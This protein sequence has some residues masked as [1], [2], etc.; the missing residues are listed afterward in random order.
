MKK[1]F[2]LIFLATL[3][4]S[5]CSTTG[6]AET[7]SGDTYISSNLPVDYEGALPVRNQLALGT[8][9]LIEANQ[10]PTAEQAKELIVLWQALRSTQNS[11]GVAQE[12]I[13]AL[14]EQIEGAMTQDQMDAIRDMQLTNTDMQTWAAE[15]GIS[16]G[17][18][19]GQGAGKNLSP[20]ARATRQAE[21]G[22]TPSSSSGSGGSAAII[23]ALIA[24]LQTLIP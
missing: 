8:L 19:G 6:T 20:E 7:T 13:S 4:L 18:G 15:N 10:A 16:M 23:D 14:L 3:L 22:R 5:A 17:A 1:L 11:S 21:E 12:E 9:L 24:N 2:I